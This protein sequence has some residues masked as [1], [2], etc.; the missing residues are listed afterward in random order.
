VRQS[1]RGRWG[2]PADVAQ[3]AVF[4]T[5]SAADFV[6]GQILHVNGGFRYE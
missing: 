5:S 1:L 6:T 4:L 3:A 2:T